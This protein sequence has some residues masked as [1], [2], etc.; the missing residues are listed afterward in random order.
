MELLGVRGDP[1]IETQR[2]Q[3]DAVRKLDALID[4]AKKRRQRQSQSSSSSSQRDQQRGEQQ[5]DDANAAAQRPG[6]RRERGEAQQ[7]SQR[8]GQQQNG[9]PNPPELE[10]GALNEVM[11]EG[12][13]EWGNLPPRIRDL[14]QQGRRDRVSSLYLR[15]TEEYYRR[16][17][18]ESSR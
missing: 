7:A 13:V 3:E 14:V 2:I 5:P 12:R 4:A 8:A 16:M 9:E 1:G 10:E 18:E 11:E 17:A 15:L 6:D